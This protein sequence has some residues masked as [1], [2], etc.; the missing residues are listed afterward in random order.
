MAIKS[1]KPTSPGRRHRKD[2]AKSK[3]TKHKPEKS[4]L[5][6]YIKKSGG[7]N[8]TGRITVRHR[9]GG[10]RR[11]LRQID[12]KRDKPDIPGKIMA[13]E[14]DPNRSAD[15]ALVFYPDGAKRYIVAPED[16]S[17]GDT[18]VS[19]SKTEIKPGNNLLLKNIP[20]G[21]PIHNLEL[22]P[23]KGGQLVRSAGS[24]AFIQGKEN[25]FAT[26]LM[27]SKEI[28]LITLK[29]KATIGQVGRAELR[30]VKLGK[31]GRRRHMGFRPSVRGVAMHPGAHPHGGGEGRSGI[32][33]PSPKSPWGKR[34]LG[35][36]TRKTKKYS[37]KFIVRD[38][39]KK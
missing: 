20:V 11:M 15:I 2:I 36:K 4:L 35:K 10:A 26:V 34:T 21:T 13:V 30:T 18:I 29:S 1:A 19:S 6:R 23:G 31:A 28:R 22:T 39:R 3:T 32:G 16:I 12:W 37:D 5:G 14:Y 25:G 33:M 9:G 17:I 27:P 8:N 38:R 24:Q 7:R